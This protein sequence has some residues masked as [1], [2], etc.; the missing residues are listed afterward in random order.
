MTRTRN[1]LFAPL[2]LG[3]P[4]AIAALLAGCGS[5]SSSSSSSSAASTPASTPAASGGSVTL[6][7][8]EFKITP[9]SAAVAQTGTITITMKNTGKVVH[10]LAVQTPS[11]VVKTGAINPGGSATL[12]VSA[13]K[14]GSYTFY[15]PI[16][17]HRNLGMA[18]TL[19]VGKGGS[20]SGGAG[21]A[22]TSST[23]SSGRSGY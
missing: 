5:S 4:I 23:S 20:S 17:G 2:A 1:S 3:A 13:A 10:A 19:V 14:A 16:D 7:E 18:G 21:V 8:S 11:G 15:C 22:P 9:A 6:S 12:T